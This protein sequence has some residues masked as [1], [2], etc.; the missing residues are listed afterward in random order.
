M[1]QTAVLL[2]C[3]T[4]AFTHPLLEMLR[5]P[6]RIVRAVLEAKI[7]ILLCTAAVCIALQSDRTGVTYF[8]MKF[9]C[10]DSRFMPTI[11]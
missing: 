1:I 2:P 7:A 9:A 3:E 4:I 8:R 11:S 6:L 10:A 5:K